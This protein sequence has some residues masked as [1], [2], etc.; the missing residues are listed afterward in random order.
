MALSPTRVSPARSSVRPS[1]GTP[2]P[3]PA[4]RPGTTLPGGTAN[5][6]RV[7]RVGNTVRRPAAPCQRATHA[8]LA[9]LNAVG[10]DGAP[11][12]LAA[13]STTETLT[14]MEGDAAVPPLCGETL[15]DT[16]LISVADLLGRYHR[17]AAS[18]DP[19]GYRWPKQV[20]QQFRT[21]LVSHNDVWPA[22]VVFSAGRAVALIDF[23][24][25]GPG[26]AEWDFAAAARS[27]VPLTRDA[28]I[29]DC[30]QGRVME[31]F[32]LFLD[33]TGLPRAER[34]RVAQAVVPNH[35]WMIEIIIES[36]AAGHSAFAD[37]W[38]AVAEPAA[39]AREW[40][41]QHQRDLLAA[42]G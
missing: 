22:N 18:F 37:V 7:A 12:V 29:D 9:H 39:H 21:A 27:W 14:F 24:L 42:A 17:A 4:S 8:L 1:A 25:A 6:G 28:D 41:W 26:C 34:R 19:H 16:A 31:R 23:D 30:R 11:R 40:C 13:D 2:V 15:T 5:R 10:F 38:R 32:R 20:P 3:S 35:D 33:A 36:A